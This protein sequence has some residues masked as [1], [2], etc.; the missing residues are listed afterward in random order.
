MRPADSRFDIRS[1][2][3]IT[4]PTTAKAATRLCS[5]KTCS[6][7]CSMGLRLLSNEYGLQLARDDMNAALDVGFGFDLVL[8]VAADMA[9][10][11]HRGADRDCAEARD[12][13]DRTAANCRDDIL[14]RSMATTI[15]M[16]MVAQNST[17]SLI[18]CD[19]P[20]FLMSHT[21]AAM[22]SIIA[23]P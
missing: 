19:R 23:R 6:I 8:A 7:M 21:R 3:H 12:E 16:Y 14:L 15:G 22:S 2:I 10:Q 13:D 17:P 18:P 20:P 9:D 4:A 5:T 1:E 11:R